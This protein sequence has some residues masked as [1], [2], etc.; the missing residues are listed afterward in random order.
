MFWI[1]G[2]VEVIGFL[3]S[4]HKLELGPGHCIVKETSTGDPEQHEGQGLQ[5]PTQLKISLSLRTPKH[6]TTDSLLS[7]EAI[8]VTGI[9]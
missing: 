2:D 6:I 3:P 7:T 1:A 5:P 4:K 8:P 9:D